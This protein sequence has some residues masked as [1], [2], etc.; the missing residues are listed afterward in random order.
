MNRQ[1]TLFETDKQPLHIHGVMCN[2]FC[3]VGIDSLIV[4]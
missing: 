4:S 3:A 1:Q 2:N